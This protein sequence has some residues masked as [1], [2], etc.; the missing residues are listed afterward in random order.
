MQPI[1]RELFSNSQIA[2]YDRV[3]ANDAKI[4]TY[5]LPEFL[6]SDTPI[7]DSHHAQWD[8][9]IFQR[10][11]IPILYNSGAL[12]GTPAW[13]DGDLVATALLRLHRAHLFRATREH[14]ENASKSPFAESVMASYRSASAILAM[15]HSSYEALVS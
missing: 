2:P 7:S 13:I 9:I 11:F 8:K 12:I 1:Q 6:Q 3:L 15:W 14:P 10:A 5:G 4:R